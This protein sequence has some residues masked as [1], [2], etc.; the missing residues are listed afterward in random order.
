MVKARDFSSTGNK[1]TKDA[2]NYSALVKNSKYDFNNTKTPK[3]SPPAQTQPKIIH[4]H[5]SSTKKPYLMSG[6]NKKIPMG[7]NK[8]QNLIP[9][10]Q[11]VS[12]TQQ[13][14]IF[15]KL[16][17][18]FVEQWD[19]AAQEETF[20]M[21]PSWKDSSQANNSYNFFRNKFYSFGEHAGSPVEFEKGINPEGR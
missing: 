18:N 6:N 3:K 14:R 13:N 11:K 10:A 9:K 5:N 21:G 20:K 17:Q 8:T 19:K 4:N 16:E 7:L 2:Q 15:E 12:Q 1:S